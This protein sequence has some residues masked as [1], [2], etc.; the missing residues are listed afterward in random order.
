MRATLW[1]AR[2]SFYFRLAPFRLLNF[3]E[4]VWVVVRTSFV[5]ASFWNRFWPQVDSVRI[6]LRNCPLKRGLNISTFGPGSLS[7]FTR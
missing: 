7:R 2:I 4:F 6:V 5:A 1:V 3:I